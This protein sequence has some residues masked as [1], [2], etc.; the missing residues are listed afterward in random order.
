MCLGTYKQEVC[1]YGFS[2]WLAHECV[3][4]KVGWC[5]VGMYEDG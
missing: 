4:G 1:M 3:C 5:C 2:G